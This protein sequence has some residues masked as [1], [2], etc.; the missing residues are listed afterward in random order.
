MEEEIMEGWGK[1][2]EDQEENME[3]EKEALENH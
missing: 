3:V 2:L 1:K